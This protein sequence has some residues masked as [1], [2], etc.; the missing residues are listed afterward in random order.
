[1]VILSFIIEAVPT[2]DGAEMFLSA[3]AQDAA[4]IGTFTGFRVSEYAQL[5]W[6]KGV[7]FHTVP[8]NIAS[9]VDE[10]KPIAFEISDFKFIL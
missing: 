2:H 10:G 1:M 5:Q 8:V 6:Q 4:I 9:V 3:V 7:E